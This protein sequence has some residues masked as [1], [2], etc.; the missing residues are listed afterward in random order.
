MRFFGILQVLSDS[1][2]WILFGPE[3]QGEILCSLRGESSGISFHFP[4]IL[5]GRFEILWDSLRWFEMV[6]DALGFLKML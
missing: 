5:E 4:G 1:C 6:W 3:M 2:P